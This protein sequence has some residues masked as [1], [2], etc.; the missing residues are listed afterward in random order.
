M[1]TE[2]LFVGV[3]PGGLV[4]ADRKVEQHG[5]YKRVALLTYDTLELQISDP[6]SPLLDEVISDAAIYQARKGE[7]FDISTSGQY[8]TLGWRLP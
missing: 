8:I 3:Y 1:P 2:R 6:D 4:Y 5:D 7:R